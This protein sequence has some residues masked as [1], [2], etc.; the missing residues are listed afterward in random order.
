MR[1][2][3]IRFG[4]D[5]FMNENYSRYVEGRA[6]KS[7]LFR[8]C[9]RAF[10]VG[11]AICAFA[12]GLKLWYGTFGM[13]EPDTGTLVS[14]T[15]IFLTA[16]LTGIG[17]FDR[18]AKFAGSGTVVPITGFANAV[19]SCAVDAKTEGFILGVGAKIFAIAGP[20]ILY[21]ISAGTVYGVI[22]WCVSLII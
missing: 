9:L 7:P 15:L 1:T 8:D 4:S 3:P 2:Y 19:V 6:E 10:L 16:L 21:G 11:G 17:V 5:D 13:P 20:V 12:Q 22:Y 14:C 18:I